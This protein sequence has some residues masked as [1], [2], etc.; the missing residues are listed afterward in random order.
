MVV[1]LLFGL[2]WVFFPLPLRLLYS[3]LNL[4]ITHL[5]SFLAFYSLSIHTR[6]LSHPS[7]HPPIATT[8]VLIIINV[9]LILVTLSTTSPPVRDPSPTIYRETSFPFRSLL[10]FLFL[11]PSPTALLLTLLLS[12][13]FPPPIFSLIAPSAFAAVYPTTF[14]VTG[15]G[16]SAD[17]TTTAVPPFYVSTHR[18]LG[19]LF[20]CFYFYIETYSS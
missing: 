4:E 8:P 7:S 14:S 12:P 16:I 6:T 20:V 15:N 17:L 10:L 13:F 3:Q 2:S 1:A 11:I 18:R 19:Y 9:F 5:L